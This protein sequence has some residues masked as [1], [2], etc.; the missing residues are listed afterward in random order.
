[1]LTKKLVRAVV[2]F[3]I[4]TGVLEAG[5]RVFTTKPPDTIHPLPEFVSNL[6]LHGNPGFPDGDLLWKCEPGTRLYFG[7][8]E[9]VNARGF[10]G[11]DFE[12]DKAAGVRRVVVLGG[13]VS[14]GQDAKL[15][16]CYTHR[17]SR[18]LNSEKPGSFEV[19][20]LSIPAGSSFQAKQAFK[21]IGVNLAPDVVILHVG[22]WHD[23]T[24]AIEC[25]DEASLER[26]RL[27]KTSRTGFTIRRSRIFQWIGY[28]L[29]PPPGSR[30]AEYQDLWKTRHMRPNGPRVSPTKFKKNLTEI[31]TLARGIGAKVLMVVPVVAEE[32]RTTVADSD[33]Y[34]SIVESIGPTIADGIVNARKFVEAKP[35]STSTGMLD[36]M[37]L[38]HLGHEQVA[39]G[40]V[41]EM[42]RIG[43][44][45]VPGLS[46]GWFF[47]EPIDLKG[48]EYAARYYVDGDPDAA[49]DAIAPL[50]VDGSLALKPGG[51]VVF[52]NITIPPGGSL[53]TGLASF[54]RRTTDTSKPEYQPTGALIQ[55]FF[56]IS[57]SDGVSKKTL[58]LKELRGR[59]AATWL[60]SPRHQVDLNE[61]TNRRVKLIFEVKGNALVACFRNPVIRAVQ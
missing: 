48:Y 46:T 52:D 12:M 2:V 45:G 19:I 42:K 33:V 43:V 61:F 50:F 58:F 49:K 55:T 28:Y 25:D 24:P 37:H 10:R 29:N 13:S 57:V 27:H 17:L 34:A 4:A 7:A 59:D 9:I 14:F 5:L 31:S 20:N 18:F 40:I 6:F 32:A 11:P 30:V 51:T 60:E 21:T 44:A 56:K 3:V 39:Q 23:F 26:I 35:G 1:M 41:D 38:S 47:Q 16:D 8:D 53:E 54:S 36:N 15:S 22:T